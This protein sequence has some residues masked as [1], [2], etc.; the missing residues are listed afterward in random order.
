MLRGALITLRRWNMGAKYRLAPW[1]PESFKERQ[2]MLRDKGILHSPD[3]S[4]YFQQLRK[5]RWFCGQ[6]EQRNGSLGS[7]QDVG[8]Q[9]FGVFRNAWKKIGLKEKEWVQTVELLLKV[10]AAK[11]LE[12]L[13]KKGEYLNKTKKCEKVIPHLDHI[14]SRQQKHSIFGHEEPQCFIAKH[15]DV[16]GIF[17]VYNISRW[18][19][20]Q[21]P[22]SLPKI[23]K[24]CWIACN[25]FCIY[26]NEILQSRECLPV[27]I[28]TWR[29]FSQAGKDLVHKYVQS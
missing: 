19:G 4:N 5:R 27:I 20:G 14:S 17:F 25:H 26:I 18:F 2:S 13:P 23:E 24:M 1:F 8:G 16:K 3:F 29:R 10:A 22:D 15:H 11:G 7:R 12:L 28:C 6:P 21:V 9:F